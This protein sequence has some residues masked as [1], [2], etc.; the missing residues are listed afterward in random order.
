MRA[1]QT[2]EHPLSIVGGFMM[3]F[4]SLFAVVFDELAWICITVA[5]V[6]LVMNLGL[7]FCQWRAE[8]R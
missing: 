6:G 4:G 3:V 1:H 7:L 2:R 5:L 8:R